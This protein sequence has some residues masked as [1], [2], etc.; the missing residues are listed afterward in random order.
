MQKKFAKAKKQIDEVKVL[1]KELDELWETITA[2]AHP[3]SI[4]AT[5]TI[6]S[7]PPLLQLDAHHQPILKVERG[8]I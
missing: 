2:A 8:G 3:R 6:A 7:L 5:A 1:E 4:R